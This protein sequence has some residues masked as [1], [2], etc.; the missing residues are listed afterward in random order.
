M[1]ILYTAVA[2]ARGGRE[3]EV[4]SDDGVIDVLLAHPK[5][6]GGP[7]GDKTNPEQLFAAGYAACFHSA[8]KR[9]AGKDKLDVTESSI[10]AHVGLGID[11]KAFGLAV[12]LVGRFPNLDEAQG[13]ELMEKAHQ[14][15][16]YSRATR[17]N[18]EVTLQ[19]APEYVI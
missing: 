5:E 12:T 18:I 4:V 19:V 17:D 16:P 15:C 2:T 1:D 13:H 11:G 7:G 10:T 6:L 9:V 8:L 14:V 3:G